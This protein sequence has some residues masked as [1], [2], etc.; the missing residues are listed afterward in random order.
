MDPVETDVFMNTFF[1]MP[2]RAYYIL[3]INLEK[4]AIK[5]LT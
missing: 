1:L 4:K 5:F 3:H 2:K